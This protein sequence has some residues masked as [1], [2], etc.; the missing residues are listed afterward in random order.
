MNYQSSGVPTE[1]AQLIDAAVNQ[2][3]DGLVVSMSNPQA[4][5]PLSSARSPPALR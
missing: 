2:K 5:R 3:P 1:Q 4:V